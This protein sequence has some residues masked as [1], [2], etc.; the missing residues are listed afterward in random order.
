MK[1]MARRARSMS[2][3]VH[4]LIILA[5]AVAY[6]AMLLLPSNVGAESITARIGDL[7]P[8]E[9]STAAG[10]SQAFGG[11][12]AVGA[13]FAVGAGKPG[14]HFCT[15]SVVHS[16]HGDLV[17][18]AAH[19]VTGISGQIAFVPGYANGKDPYGVWKVAAVYA[20]QAWQSSQ[21]PDDD[22]AF[23]RLADAGGVPI[24]NV[25]GAERLGVGWPEPALVRL[26]GYPDDADQ[27]V[28]CVNQAKFFS[29]TQLE[30]DCGGYS[31]GTSGAPFLADMSA[32]SGQGTVI[33]VLGGYEQ[34][35]NTSDVSYASA[36]GPAVTA[37][38]QRAEAGG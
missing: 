21:D 33:G 6:G 18:T 11:V 1:W 17:V 16:T 4:V 24:E 37:L 22:V 27:P 10:A 29:S 14:Q 25:T 30:F 2:S 9:L 31:F 5:A 38:Y 23:L 15:A 35:G 3:R 19:C 20:D 32:F 34:G 12:A 28:S 26:I 36:F 8:R 13:L 7:M